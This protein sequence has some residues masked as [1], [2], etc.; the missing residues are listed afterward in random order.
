MM[1]SELLNTPFGISLVLLLGLCVGSFLNVVIH[2]LPLMIEREDKLLAWEIVYG[3]GEQHP[4]VAAGRFNLFF[5]AS[6]C[7]N[8]GHKIRAWENMPILSYLLQKGRCRSCGVSFSARYLWVEALTAVASGVVAWRFSQLLP[9]TFALVFTWML[10]AL[11]F[12]DAETCL[13]PDRLTLPLM[14]L[15]IF[16]AWYGSVMQFDTA[17]LFISLSESVLGAM[18]GYLSLWSVYW[19]F[20]II[21]GR[22]GMG[23]GDFKLLAALSAWQGVV[24][25]PIILLLS[26]ICGIIYF[27]INRIGFGKPAPFGPYL[28][29]AGW[30]TFLFGGEIASIMGLLPV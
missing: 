10:I 16:A 13:L 5:P 22:E 25:L 27:M 2:R 30:I 23:Y 19:I 15:G 17:G 7:A 11:I 1:Q 28:A 12:I 26:S 20:K 14:W 29:I 9:M 21:T 18:V 24:M 3:E 4:D 8:C 6:R